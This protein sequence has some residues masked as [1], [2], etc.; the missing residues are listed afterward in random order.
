[1]IMSIIK[2]FRNTVYLAIVGICIT[3]GTSS[4]AA[5]VRAIT[6][7]AKTQPA[8][9]VHKVHRMT[10]IVRTLNSQTL[11]LT[12]GKKYDLSNVQVSDFT[13]ND[14]GARTAEMTFVDKKL[15][16]VVIR[17]IK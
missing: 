17:K 11:L 14:K 1:M 7:V 16:E 8:T 10:H 3:W 2:P 5:T 4:F 9:S 6:D 13:G 12:N 15:K